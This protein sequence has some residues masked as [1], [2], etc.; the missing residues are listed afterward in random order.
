MDLSE[1]ERNANNMMRTGK[2]CPSCQF[3]LEQ[4][5]GEERYTCHMCGGVFGTNE[6][7]EI[8]VDWFKGFE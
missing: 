1:A 7:G 4:I 8:Q 2:F 5:T 6:K 3:E